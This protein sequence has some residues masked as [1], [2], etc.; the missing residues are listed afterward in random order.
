[1]QHN[2]EPYGRLSETTV[3]IKDGKIAA[4]FDSNSSDIDAIETIDGK[5]QWLLPGFVD[6]HTHLV[7]GGDRAGEFEMRLQG[8]S[9]KQIAEQ[10]GG[11]KSTVKATRAA[12]EQVLLASAL[13]RAKRLAEEGVT[14]IEVKSGYGLD[15]ETECRMLA[16]AKQL[17][18]HL[19]LSIVTTYLGAHALPPE[20]QNDAD[21]YIDYICTHVLPKVAQENAANA[22]D[23]FCES[24]GFDLEQTERV[25]KAAQQHGLAVKAHV[26]QLSDMKGAVLAA[27]YNALSVDHIEYLSPNDIQHLAHSGSVAV[28]LPGAF[29]YLNETQKP[30]V[31][32]LR[33]HSIPMAVATDLNPGSSPI[34]SLL[35]VMNMA[36]VLF[37]L[38]PEESVRGATVHAAKALGLNDRGV[39]DIEM[40]ADLTL[41][42]IDT[43]AELV[44]TINGHRPTHIW[45][46]GKHV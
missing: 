9:Y 39:I 23:V 15:E 24:I 26:E 16:V 30:P 28:L 38:T 19:P 21:G 25:F 31:E 4:L 42:D 32:A 6:C 40:Q 3:A 29:Y 10:G 14:T 45:Q 7:Y 33:Q 17:E 20:F 11:I 1:M 22:V 43:P 2:G 44:Y 27:K 5:G 34:A 41:W 46:R 12:N 36:C 35:T 13:K 8:V 37:G 18:S